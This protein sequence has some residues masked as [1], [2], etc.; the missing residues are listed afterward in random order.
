MRTASKLSRETFGRAA[1]HGRESMAQLAL[2]TPVKDEALTSLAILMESLPIASPTN[3]VRDA[4]VV[5][6]HGLLELTSKQMTG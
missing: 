2:L 6:V 1:S 3:E 5:A 4:F